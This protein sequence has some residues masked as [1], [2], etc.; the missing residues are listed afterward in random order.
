MKE[1]TTNRS[2]LFTIVIMG[3]A[4]FASQFGAGNLIF[5]PYLRQETGTAWLTGFLGFFIMDVG[6]A[7]CAIFSGVFNARGDVDGIVGKLGNIPG[8]VM[9]TLI[10]L[11]IGPGLVIPRTAATTYEM[12]IKT[13]IPGL[14]LWAFGIVFFSIVLMLSIKSS[15]VVDIVGNYLTPVLLAVMVVLIILGIVHPMGE[16]TNLQETVAFK[17]GI[18]NGYQTMDG[19]G[20]IL[21]TMMLVTA[22][23]GYGYKDKKDVLVMIGGADIIA[24][25]LLGLVY[26]GLTYL[27]ATSTAHDHMI[28]LEQAP[29]L[30]AITNKLLGGYGV[31][32]LSV[33]VLFACLTTAIC[34]T[35]VAGNYFSELSNG[36][37]KYKWIVIAVVIFSYLISNAGLSTIISVAAPILS[38]L[39]PPM[40]VLV[41]LS[42]LDK[43]LCNRNVSK[44]AAYAAFATAA[45]EVIADLTGSLDFI[46]RLPLGEYGVAWILPALIAG[47]IGLLIKD[48]NWHLFVSEGQ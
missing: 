22:V 5:P 43:V 28:G 36:R 35:S 23:S 46:F 18:L 7:A 30:I 44:L 16:I 29:L 41:V 27:G 1:N 9:V 17:S 31:I 12:G 11:C 13:L 3:L 32:A 48:H 37:I 34:L 25:V 39:Y 8:K 42:Y 4:L 45:I 21:M 20:G 14:P 10:I 47:V 38:M 15:K 33:I 6:L 40:I 19:L 26:L 2:R 24:S